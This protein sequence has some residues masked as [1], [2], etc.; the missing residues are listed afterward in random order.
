MALRKFGAKIGKNVIYRQRTRVKYPW[1]LEIGDNCWIG[2]G[3][4]LH[5]QGKLIIGN[6]VVIS[7]ESFITTGSHDTKHSMDLIVRDVIIESGAWITSR[8]I[9][10]SGVKIGKNSII[11][12]GSVVNKSTEAGNI[13]GGNPIKF[14]KER[15]VI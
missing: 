2:E 15:E 12:P 1:K 7:Q 9:V 4:W 10:L 13:Y 6:D 11:T 3:V 5:N 14:I 8:C